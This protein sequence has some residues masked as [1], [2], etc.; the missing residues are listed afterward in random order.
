M[1]KKKKKV[2][3]LWEKSQFLRNPSIC[4]VFAF[5]FGSP[6]WFRNVSKLKI[7]IEKKNQ[8]KNNQRKWFFFSPFSSA[9]HSYRNAYNLLVVF[10]T[11]YRE[12]YVSLEPKIWVNSP[13][14]NLLLLCRRDL[15]ENIPRKKKNERKN[16]SENVSVMLFVFSLCVFVQRN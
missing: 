16:S 2:T 10:L 9:L 8:A 11:L 4:L 15:C 3:V 12:S 5:F 1:E 13:R 7:A 14:R 6:S